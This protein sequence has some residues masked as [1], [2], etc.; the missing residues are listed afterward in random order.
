MGG[1]SSTTTVRPADAR[2]PTGPSP[3]QVLAL[4]REAA[5][6][7]VRAGLWCVIE[8]R[9]GA[10]DRPWEPHWLICITDA[11][12]VASAIAEWLSGRADGYARL[13]GYT[14]DTLRRDGQTPTPLALPA[15]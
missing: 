13:A 12:G 10:A 9:T 15:A 11:D 1:V 8:T 6:S 3:A 4:W 2:R 7:I 14:R 5:S